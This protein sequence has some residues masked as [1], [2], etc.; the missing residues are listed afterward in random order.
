MCSGGGGLGNVPWMC[1]EDE[2][3]NTEFLSL[4]SFSCPLK[5]GS[6]PSLDRQGRFPPRGSM[7][8]GSGRVVGFSLRWSGRVLC[9][10]MHKLSPALLYNTRVCGDRSDPTSWLRM[11]RCH[12]PAPG[13]VAYPKYLGLPARMSASLIA[14]HED[15][16]WSFCASGRC[17]HS[18]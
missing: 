15:K 12:L 10:V 1:N 7:G 11:E 17:F 5:N 14:P 18:R 8:I 6:E 16:R 3:A 9:A 4:G 2:G 13:R